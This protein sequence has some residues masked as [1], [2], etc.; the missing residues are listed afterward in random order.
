MNNSLSLLAGAAMMLAPLTSIVAPNDADKPATPPPP[1]AHLECGDSGVRLVGFS[2]ALNKTS[3]G[4]FAVS[5]LSGIAYDSLSGSYIVVADRAGSVRSHTFHL[6]LTLEGETV[7]PE[8]IGTTVLTAPDGS[9]YTGFTLDPEGIVHRKD[10]SMFVAS[11]GGS[12]AGEQPEIHR[13]DAHGA[14]MDSLSVPAKFLIGTNNLSFE[15]LTQ[16]PGGHA[17]FTAN[18]GPLAA[19]GRTADLRSRIRLLRYLQDES[20]QFAPAGEF[21]YLAEPGRTAGD[22]GVAELLAVT[23]TSV[24]VLER[25]FVSGLGNTIRI[26]QVSLIGAM[27]VSDEASLATEGLLPVQKSLLVD[28]VSCP[29]GGVPQT[30]IQP[31]DLFE[32]FEAMTFGPEL[33]GGLRSLVLVSDDNGSS[34]QKTRI[35]VLGVPHP[36]LAPTP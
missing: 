3:F 20:G 10:G 25:G 1:F 18:E 2:D 17:L 31:N 30:A 26:F 24:L 6:S 16:S 9:P 4:H 27:D 8:V 33:A 36:L 21:F 13:F 23:P 7:E 12:A 22:I 14:H 19:D 11:E 29:D 32:N 28:L 35:V 34:S 5:E 15:S